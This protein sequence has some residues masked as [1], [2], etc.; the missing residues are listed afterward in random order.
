MKSLSSKIL[1]SITL[2]L[3]LLSIPFVLNQATSKTSNTK[4]S[5]HEHTILHT[6]D[7]HGHYLEE[8]GEFIGAPKL[9][10]IKDETNPDLFVDAGDIFQGYPAS[11]H[12]KGEAMAKVINELDYDAIAVGNHELDFGYDQLM[13]LKNQVKAPILSANMYKDGERPFKSSTF[14]KRNDTNYGIIGVNTPDTGRITRISSMKGV[15]FKDPIQSATNEALKIQD[16]SDV[17]VVLSHLGDKNKKAAY[18]GDTL[19]KRLTDNPAIHKPV[20]VVDAHSH[21]VLKEGRTYKGNAMGQTG[22]YLR[23]IGQIDFNLKDGKFSDIQPSLISEGETKH[24]KPDSKL[25]KVVKDLYHTFKKETS[26][27]I[28]QD[29]PVTYQSPLDNDVSKETSLGNV[30]TDAIETYEFDEPTDFA[31]SN[32]SALE[33]DIPKGSITINDVMNA[34]PYGVTSA[35]Q[36]DVKGHE[37]KAAF[38]HSLAQEVVNVNGESQLKFYGGFLQASDSISVKYDINQPKG[39]RVTEIKVK[40]K[41]TGKFE[42]LDNDK[43]YHVAMHDYIGRGGQGYSMFGR[44]IEEGDAMDKVFMNYLKDADLS[45]YE[46]NQPSRIIPMS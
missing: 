25:K 18:R 37:V 44:N 7:I 11:D 39:S 45:K 10:T 8:K 9:K 14:V 28:R 40:N 22:R 30:F 6:N 3:A 2:C 16:Q 35:V 26:E 31:V 19:L 29:N 32:S 46:G 5:S 17:I 43:T 36:T 34:I 20:V 4:S 12:S 13:K 41:E 24:V 27:V 38:E 21:T 42:P 1:L 23:N 15:E 33:K